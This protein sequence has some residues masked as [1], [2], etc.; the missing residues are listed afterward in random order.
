MKFATG[1]LGTT[2][3][4]EVELE[5]TRGSTTSNMPTKLN[6]VYTDEESCV[7]RSESEPIE[8]EIT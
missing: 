1:P 5:F 7:Q 2:S 4:V 8:A 3:R 6:H